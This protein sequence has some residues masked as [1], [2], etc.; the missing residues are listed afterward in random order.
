MTGAA[1]SAPTR[2]GSGALTARVSETERADLCIV[3]P[4]RNEAANIPMLIE[5]LEDSLGDSSW[6]WSVLFVD[7]SDDRTPATVADLRADHDNLSLLHRL[8]GE[9]RGGLSG[10]VAAGFQQSDAWVIV[11]MDG[12]LQHPPEVVRELVG[13]VLRE[14]SDIAI[15][16]RYVSG[17]SAA[18]LSGKARRMVSRLFVAMVH[19]LVPPSRGVRDPM[20]GFFAVS[21]RTID[22]LD[23][24]GEGFKILLELLARAPRQRVIEIPF[25]FDRRVHGDSKAGFKEGARFLRHLARLTRS[26]HGLVRTALRRAPNHVPLAAILAVQAWLSARLL[27]RNTAFLDEATYISAGKYVVR[28]WFHRTP[29]LHFPTYFSGAPTIY[30]VLAGIADSIGGLVGARVL[31]LVFMLLA[32]SFCYLTATRLFGRP[33]GWFAAAVFVTS[34]GTQFLGA[35]ATFDAMAL[36]LVACTA[37]IVVRNAESSGTGSWFYLA[38]PVLALANA[39]KYAS[40]L[41]DPVVIG[42]AFFTVWGRVGLRAAARASGTLTAGL[43]MVLAVLLAASPRS[44]LTG[45]ASTTLN[46]APSTASVHRVLHLS[47]LWVGGIASLAALALVVSVLT[48]VRRKSAWWQVGVLAVLASSV[49]LAPANQ[50]RIH[51]A[52]SLSKHVTFGGWFGAVA[53]GWILAGV[54]GRRP[55]DLARCAA[56]STIL[57]PMGAAG[58]AQANRHF[59][60]WPNSHPVVAAIRSALGTTN[61]RVLMDDAPV[62]RYYLQDR[63]QLSHWVDTYYF[64]YTPPGGTRLVGIPAYVAAVDNGSFNVIALDFGER[65]QVDTAVAEAIHDSGRYRWVGNFAT[66]DEYGRSA[67]VV[68]TVRPVQ[69]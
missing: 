23:L 48:A 36:M 56:A 12:D 54:T 4:T 18:G 59:D 29:D 19:V 10:A 33:A 66:R 53:A 45:V 64:A 7:D 69:S 42:L 22:A 39:T 24:R 5:R 1:S 21:R 27:A 57:V 62:G 40:A 46:R 8:P 3:V 31:S 61:G 47:W 28:S 13:P 6:S 20:S 50:A 26:R 37:W 41:F 44:Y 65:K 14:E 38:I 35:F 16:S 25:R 17:A 2:P 51:T 30:P 11:V 15:A 52:T 55:L 43:I 32:T 60:E 49:L 34:Q 68:W 58:I 9:R 63:V 67:Y